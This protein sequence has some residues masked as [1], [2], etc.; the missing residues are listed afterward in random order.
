MAWV[1]RALGGL[2]EAVLSPFQ[3]W[4]A[5]VGL[6]VVSLVVAIVMLLVFRVASNQRAMAGVKRRIHAGIFEVRLFNDDV[7]ALFSALDVLRHNLTYLRLSLA[8]LPWVIIPLTLLV[9]QL[10]FYYGYD[11]FAPGQSAVVTVRLDESAVPAGGAAPAIGLDAPAGLSVQTPLVWMAAEREAAWRVGMDEP[12]DYD[13]AVTLDGKSVTK[14]VR[15][16]NQVGWRTPGRFE[17]G[18]VNQLLYPAEA[19]IASD[20]AIESIEVTYP[21]RVVS[22]LGMSTGWMV[23]FVVMVLAF[24]WLLRTRFGVV[25]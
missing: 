23:S 24:T 14:R 18:L 21:E 15:V 5:A 10:Q 7:R 8:P 3:A 25:I 17:A 12:G 11:G 9:A 19:P 13:L 22:L 16:S 20:V 4:P 6:A 1:N 2:A